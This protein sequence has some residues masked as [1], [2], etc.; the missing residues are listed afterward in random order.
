MVSIDRVQAGAARY[1]ESEILPK[2]SGVNKWLVGAAASAY[3]AEAP[4]LLRKLNENKA[5]A[6]LNLVDEAGNIDIE[7]IYQHLKPMAAKCPA[8]V[9]LPVVGSLT[10]TEHDIDSLYALMV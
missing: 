8:T 4:A 5:V 2:M 10:F 6:A 1:L 9:T 3:I 7:K